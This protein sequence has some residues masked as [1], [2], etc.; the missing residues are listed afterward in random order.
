MK[1]LE[2]EE[3]KKSQE[4][5]TVEELKAMEQ[6]IIALA[7]ETD[8]TIATT[9][10][11]LP[12]ENRKIVAEAIQ[13]F[14]NKQEIQWQYTLSM[15]AMYDF[16]SSEEKLIPFPQ[17]D[18]VL[19]ALGSMKFV[20]YDEWAKVIAINK[21]FEPL[22]EQYA[23]ITEKAYTIADKHNLLMEKLQLNTPI[24]DA[25]PGTPA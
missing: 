6:E 17:L 4:S 10:F 14:L 2:R 21:Y 20:G 19:R 1:E 13:Y 25:N 22:R 5:K 24:G 16:W 15:V 23:E 18:A 9:N 7:E 3:F 12:T 11:E 8:K